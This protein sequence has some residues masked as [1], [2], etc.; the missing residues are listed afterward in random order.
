MFPAWVF[1]D[2]FLPI[3]ELDDQ[4]HATTIRKSLASFG[5]WRAL[6]SAFQEQAVET[7]KL[8]PT[9][10]NLEVRTDEEARKCEQLRRA[11]REI[12]PDLNKE[13]NFCGAHMD[14]KECYL[15]LREAARSRNSLQLLKLHCDVVRATQQKA[16]ENPMIKLRLE[17]EPLKY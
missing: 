14:T 1:D 8:P 12:L 10:P 11:I 2:Q 7:L 3:K 5:L 16:M 17:R 13:M 9:D 6:V 4:T 15:L